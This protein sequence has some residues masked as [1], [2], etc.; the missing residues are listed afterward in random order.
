MKKTNLKIVLVT[1]F[2]ALLSGCTWLN[3][4]TEGGISRGKLIVGMVAFG[5]GIAGIVHSDSD[6]GDTILPIRP[7]TGGGDDLGP[8]TLPTAMN[9]RTL[10]DLNAYDTPTAVSAN[11]IRNLQSDAIGLTGSEVT[12]TASRYDDAADMPQVYVQR[13]EFAALGVWVNGNTPEIGVFD[14]DN[15]DYAFL[16]DNVVT[17]RPASGMATYDIE[18]DA[19]YKSVNFFPDGSLTMDFAANTFSGNIGVDGAAALNHFGSA[20]AMVPDAS[21]NPRPL[22]NDDDLTIN[23]AGT[24]LVDTI[25]DDGFSSTPTIS[26]ATGFFDDLLT[27]ATGTLAGRFY[28]A[29]AAGYDPMAGDPSEIA[30]AGMFADSDGTG[31]LHFGF[32]GRCTANCAAG[33]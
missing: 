20:T 7:T 19:T 4:E 24:G 21:G 16:G 22:E 14:H 33:D 10:A 11:L 5:A 32:V 12:I 31:D 9:G 6:S 17:S 28:N 29:D 30:G 23:L 3:T 8:M 15:Y 18:G 25:T 13:L 1:I 26:T 2:A 27:G